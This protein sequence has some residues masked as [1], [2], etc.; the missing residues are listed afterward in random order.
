MG[1]IG[2]DWTGLEERG[3]E[4]RDERIDGVADSGAWD[5]CVHSV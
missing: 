1:W 5:V 3:R 2:L 4:G